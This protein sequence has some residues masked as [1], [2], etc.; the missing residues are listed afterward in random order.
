MKCKS[1]VK[2]VYGHYLYQRGGQ[3][4]KFPLEFQQNPQPLD[5]HYVVEH[6]GHRAAE[7]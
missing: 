3:V 4:G 7:I 6:R 1:E 5:P 2:E